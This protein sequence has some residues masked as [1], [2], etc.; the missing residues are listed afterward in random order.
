MN[1]LALPVHGKPKRS[2]AL[3]KTKD[4]FLRL[5]VDH[6]F[7]DYIHLAARVA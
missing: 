6:Q 1:F 3:Q 5:F 7:G 4:S 2:E